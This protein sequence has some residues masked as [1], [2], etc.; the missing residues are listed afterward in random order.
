MKPNL[1]VTGG[2]GFLGSHFVRHQLS[3]GTHSVTNIDCLT[4]AGDLR[5]LADV[6]DRDDYDFAELDIADEASIRKLIAERRPEAIVHYAAESHV[7][8]SESDPDRFYRTNVEGTRVLLDAAVL[9]GVRR[10]VHVSTD[11]VYGSILKGAFTESDKPP[12]TGNAASPYSKSKALADDLARSYADR[13]EV[14]VVRPTNAF[15]PWQYPEKVFPRWVTRGLRSEPMLVWGDGLYIRQWLY[16]EDFARAVALVLQKGENG[17]AY[18]IGPVHDPEITNLALAH[19]LAEFL[20]IGQDGIQMTGYDRPD[21]DR[22]YAVDSSK[23]RALGWRSG[24]VW[25]QFEASVNWYRDHRDWWEAHVAEAESIYADS[26]PA[27]KAGS[28]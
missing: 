14:V 7:T 1:C 19:W 16:A 10:F 25:Q 8:R 9:A 12:G 6:S 26:A 2:A 24:D 21:H 28:P 18:N 13:L 3:Q 15:G 11:E 4:Y 22:R 5:R 20:G 23:I 27:N 17:E